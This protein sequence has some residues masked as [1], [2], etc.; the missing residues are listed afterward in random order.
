MSKKTSKDEL[1]R[2][3]CAWNRLVGSRARSPRW[4]A[5][6][7]NMP[8]NTPPA[9][10]SHDS[11]NTQELSRTHICRRP[12]LLL[13]VLWRRVHPGLAVGPRQLCG[14]LGVTGDLVPD[15]VVPQRAS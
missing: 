15:G 10:N 14:R 1:S 8:T 4:T 2:G 7:T 13:H 5:N 6:A 9:V 11:V 3:I 12:L